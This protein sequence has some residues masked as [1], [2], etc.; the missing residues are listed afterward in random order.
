MILSSQM[1]SFYETSFHPPSISIEKIAS[2]NINHHQ[3]NCF[4][5][6]V[7]L[8]SIAVCIYIHTS[9]F[10]IMDCS[11]ETYHIMR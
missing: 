5:Q 3:I 9:E 7:Y 1:T 6:S 10:L 2:R 4:H 11:N 8:V